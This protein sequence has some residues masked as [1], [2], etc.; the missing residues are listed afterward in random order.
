[1]TSVV[2]KIMDDGAQESKGEL[3][4]LQSIVG[5]IAIGDLLKTTFGPKGMDKILQP[6]KEGPIDSTPIV[7]ND[8]ATILKSISIDNPAAKILVDISKQQDNRCGDGTTGVVI[9]ASELLKQ[10]ERLL[11]QKIHPQVIIAGYRMALEEARKALSS[12][13]FNNRENRSAFETDLLNIARTTLSS[14]LLTIE[15]DHFANLALKAILRLGDNMNL[16]YIQI[17]KKVGGSLQDSFLEEGFILEKK[18]GVGQPKVMRNCKILVANTPMDTDKIKIYGAKVTVDSMDTVQEIEQAEKKK[19]Y[20]KVQKILKHGCNVFI[21]RQL[22]YN[23][24]DQ[25]FKE[26]GIVAIEH[27]DF[28]GVERLGA[29]LGADI[30][31]T[32]DNPEK[33]VLGTC[34]LM[35][36]IMIGEDEFI[37]FSGCAKNQACT[38]VLRGAS[39]HI[40]DEAERSLHDALAVLF[41]TVSDGRVVYGGGC[42]EMLMSVSVDELSKRVEGKKSLAIEAFANALRQIPTIL[43][44]NGGYDSAE[45]VTKLRALHYKGSSTYGIDFKVAQPGDMKELG[46]LESFESKLSQICSAT[47]AAEM[48]LRVDDIIRCAPRQRQGV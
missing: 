23:Y 6:I 41:Q 31:S 22:I 34:E 40:L 18:I 35:D 30:V 24:P 17:I 28:E 7:T 21:N 43:L 20:N 47:E 25:L 1:M 37:R 11:D 2:P 10:A 14:K 27:A 42:S 26:A 16:D 5:A 8:G 19:M 13:S 32:F 33:T 3:A 45:I 12:N 44:D 29:V 38:I 4:R 15:K 9:L 36:T 48:I 39:S 46:I